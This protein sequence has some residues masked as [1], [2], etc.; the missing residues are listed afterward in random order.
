[1]YTEG[2]KRVRPFP[3]V[4][5]AKGRVGLR[6][7]IAALLTASVVLFN[8]QS[9][10]KEEKPPSLSQ[11]PI[12]RA[13]TLGSE[14]LY[15]EAFSIDVSSEANPGP[16]LLPTNFGRQTGDLDEMLKSRNIRALVMINPVSFFYS[17]GRPRGMLYEELEQLQ[18]VINKK[19]RTDNLKIKIN[20]IPVRPD[21]LG[22]ALSQ[23]VGDFIAAGVVVTPGRQKR[24]AFTKPTMKNVTEVIVT[25]RE[26]AKLK[27][28][29][30]LVAKDI[31][32]NPISRSYDSLVKINED[33]AKVGRPLLS[34]KAADRNLQ[35]DDLIEM[36][37][38]RLIPATVAMRERAGLW[39]QILPNIK[40]HP[41]LVV[42]D[43]GQLAWVMRQDNPQLKRLLDDFVE[44]HGERTSFGNTLL[45]RY[46]KDTQWIKDSTASSE[47]K[48]FSVYLEYF[49]KYAAEYKFDY[50]MI[51]ALGYQESQLDQ[52]KR[53]RNGAVG[54]MQVIP[55]YAAAKPINVPDVS[56][57]DKNILAGVRILNNIERNYFND[58][59]IDR[60]DKTLFTFAAYNAGPHR[61]ERLRMKARDD[62]LDPKTWFG[63]VELETAEDIGEET[64]TFVSN[65]YKYYV[66]YK[67]AQERKLEVQKTMAEETRKRN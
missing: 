21:E 31:Y 52:S 41:E 63:N 29:D 1:M 24:F 26:L 36:V 61:I 46:L 15:P 35:E 10:S 34:V 3:S 11:Q 12:R 16:L 66:A 59:S 60:V 33:R 50:L 62:G 65:I 14:V 47:M 2:M 44:T 27:S 37:N 67:L 58:P 17:H 13:D 7:Q 23:G 43:E 8:M 32:V 38:A 40:S 19:Y 64:V 20:F 55:K 45:R 51:V 9:C 56:T 18:R 57:A 6:S 53:S 4:A 49:K 54:I 5:V 28:L 42:A 22:S 30:D 25:G 48:K 39:E